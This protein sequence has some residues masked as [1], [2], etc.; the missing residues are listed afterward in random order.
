MT[1]TTT[2]GGGRPLRGS[3]SVTQGMEMLH[4]AHIRAV[5]AAAGCMLMK[6]E[7]DINGIDWQID[8]PHANHL[9]DYTSSIKVQLKATGQVTPAELEGKD[10]FSFT[11]TNKH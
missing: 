5:A 4:D 7:P 9:A 1:L 11:L 8:H 10:S 3:V 2:S 6:P